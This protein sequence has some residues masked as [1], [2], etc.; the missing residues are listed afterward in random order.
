MDIG[1]DVNLPTKTCDDKHCPFHGQ[2]SVRGQILDGTIVSDKMQ[3]SAVV[4]REYQ[5]K[6]E[7]Y[8]RFE[9]RSSKVMVHNPPCLEAKVGDHV[10]IME[11][12]PLSKN[13]SYVVIDNLDRR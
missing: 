1:V 6:I 7:K 3:N 4:K 13:I 11:C 5:R 9:K 10:R 2:L 8:E 12:R